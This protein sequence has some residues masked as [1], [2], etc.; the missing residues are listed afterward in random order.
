MGLLRPERRLFMRELREKIRNVFDNSSDQKEALSGIRQLLVPNL[1]K[2]ERPYCG[3]GLH[4]FIMESF[5][6]YDC[7]RHPDKAAGLLWLNRGFIEDPR[8]GDWE[9]KFSEATINPEPCYE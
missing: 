2:R 3:K 4:R 5:M 1:K 9:I 7:V 6:L 8:L